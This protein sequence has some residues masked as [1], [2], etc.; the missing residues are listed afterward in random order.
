[1][2]PG[3]N[4]LERKNK[5]KKTLALFL[6]LF[7]FSPLYSWKKISKFLYPVTH[8]ESLINFFHLPPEYLI[9]NASATVALTFLAPAFYHYLGGKS[10]P[11]FGYFHKII[12][13]KMRMTPMDFL[14][15]NIWNVKNCELKD[16]F[17]MLRYGLDNIS[18]RLIYQLYLWLRTGKFN[19]LC[20][21]PGCNPYDYEKQ[22]MRIKL[23]VLLIAGSLDKLANKDNIKMRVFDKIG[24]KD[25]TFK[26]FKG[27][28]HVDLCRGRKVGKVDTYIYNWVKRH[29][30]Q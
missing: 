27:F 23:P 19:E 22:I 21:A 10:P 11:D 3:D 29:G 9:S 24:S 1:M 26:I 15:E 30:N 7:I 14:Q 4:S 25:K 16:M 6:T 18:P 8:N 13:E 17:Y 12:Q 28:G 5:L 20:D 2:I